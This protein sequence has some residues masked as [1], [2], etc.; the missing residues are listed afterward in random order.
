MLHLTA[1]GECVS[2][3]GAC[4]KDVSSPPASALLAVLATAFL[5]RS[6]CTSHSRSFVSSTQGNLWFLSTDS[7][8]TLELNNTELVE[9]VFAPRLFRQPQGKGCNYEDS[10]FQDSN[11]PS[12]GEGPM[13]RHNGPTEDCVGDKDE[14]ETLHQRAMEQDAEKKGCLRSGTTD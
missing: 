2:A 3:V 10:N 9:K 13:V 12:C 11:C 6:S 14:D 5:V 8:L 1:K 7:Y 4:K